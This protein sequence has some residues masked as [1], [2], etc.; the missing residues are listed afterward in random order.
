[1]LALLVVTAFSYAA[2]LGLSQTRGV[3]GA[4]CATLVVMVVALPARKGFL[5]ILLV[6]LFVTGVALLNS[7]ILLQRGI[8]Y[9]PTLWSGGLRLMLDNWLWG[10][11]FNQYEIL[12]P[13][14]GAIY[15]HPHNFF[16][17]TGMR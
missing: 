3:W 9:R 12:V 16:L 14:T 15:K 11:G 10:V 2:F 4:L 1:M 7:E 5:A 6:V 13:S 8:S 17:D